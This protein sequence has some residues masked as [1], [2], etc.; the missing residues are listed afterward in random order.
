MS[1][2]VVSRSH[3]RYLVDA[4]A[5]LAQRTKVS[6]RYTENLVIRPGCDKETKAAIGQEL[7]NENI[8]SVQECYPEDSLDEL[9]GPIGENYTLTVDD[10][11]P[12]PFHDWSLV[13]IIKACDC[14]AYQ[15]CE[16]YGWHDSAARQFTETI[17]DRVCMEL[18]GY[19]DA[20]WQINEY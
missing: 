17:I 16:H 19:D 14:Y 12:R 15:S 8:K 3:I 4:A 18:P 1:A 9:P 5:Y 10:F 11:P 13:Q 20:N 2:F 7:W 6:F